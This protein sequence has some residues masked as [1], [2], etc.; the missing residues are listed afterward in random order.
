MAVFMRRSS[1][2]LKNAF[3]TRAGDQYPG[4]WFGPGKQDPVKRNGVLFMEKPRPPGVARKWEDWELPYYVG[5]GAATIILVVGLN[6][7]PE[8]RINV[9]AK[10]EALRREAKK[11]AGSD[12]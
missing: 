7:R 11:E 5:F 3:R 4:G 8:T 6:A 2:I 12:D 1:T 10:E 9:W